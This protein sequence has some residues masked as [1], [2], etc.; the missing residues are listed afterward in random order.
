MKKKI[1]ITF[2]SSGELMV[3]LNLVTGKLFKTAHRHLYE[4][5]KGKHGDGINFFLNANPHLKFIY[6]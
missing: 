5:Y 6:P 4:S 2:D 1:V 3:L